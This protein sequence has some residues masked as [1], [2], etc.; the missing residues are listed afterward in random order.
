MTRLTNAI[1]EEVAQKIIDKTFE[2]RFRKF[3]ADAA[4]L[5]YQLRDEFLGKDKDAYL[6]LNPKLQVTRNHLQVNL[7]RDARSYDRWDFYFSPKCRVS[8]TSVHPGGAR[9]GMSGTQQ[10]PVGGDRFQMLL[11]DELTSS[12]KTKLLKHVEAYEALA[13]DVSKLFSKI[14]EQLRNCTTVKKLNELWPEA[15]SYVPAQ[16]NPIA[17]IVDRKGVNELIACMKKGTCT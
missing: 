2:Q 15:V 10:E 3:E 6:G 5:A 12:M 7:K 14:M 1:R 16:D 17:V 13:A 4:K 11:I 9:F 8:V